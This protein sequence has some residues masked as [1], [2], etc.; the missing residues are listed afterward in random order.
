MDEKRRE[1]LQY[2]F[3]PRSIGILGASS[4][5][6][7]VSGR[8]LAY[9]LR[10]GY[11]GKIYPIN[12]KYGE[13][14][15]VKCYPTLKEVPGEIDTLIV[16]IPAREI[17][18]NLESGLER[19]VKAAVIISGGFAEIGE[20]GRKLQERLTSFA[21]ETGMLIYGPNTTGFLSLVNRTVATF[22]QGLEVI[23]EMVPGRA[24]LITQSGAFGAAIFVRAMRVGLG[25]SH[26][27]ATGNEADLEFCDFLEYMVDDPHT[28]VIVGFLAGVED[29]QNLIKGLDMAAKK[30]KP[31]VLLKVGG[32]QAGKRAAYSHTGAIVGSSRAYDA[33]FRQKGVIVARDIGELIDYSMAL[34]TTSPPRGRRVGIMTE[35]GG[36]GVL[37]TERCSELGLEVSEI[38]GATRERLKKVVP[39]V[40]SVKNPVDLTGQSLSIPSLVKGAIEV[41]LESED[42]D[43]VLPLLMMSEAT[44]KERAEDLVNLLKQHQGGKTVIVCWP[45]GPR[46]WIQYLM[47]KGIHV[48]ETP[49]RCAQTL[50]ALVQYA[51]FRQQYDGRGSLDTDVITDLPWDRKERALEVIREAKQRGE[52]RLSEYEG[53]RLLQ[54]Y[55]IPTAEEALA[56]SV[57][58]A[59]EIARRIGYPVVAKLISPDIPHKTEAGVVALNIESKAGLRKAY[60]EIIERGRAYRPDARVEGVLIQEMVSARGV[61]TIVGVSHEDPFGPMILFGLGGIFVETMQDVAIRILPVT[62]RDV[63]EMIRQIRGYPILQ[64][65]RGRSPADIEAL[66]MVLLKTA[67]L[68][69]EFKGVIAE[70]DINPLIVSEEGKGAKAVDALVLLHNSSQSTSS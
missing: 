30:G 33:V 2:L 54:A 27:A 59:I 31:V 60:Q 20:E 70:I 34:G 18:P 43:I 22:S 26:W 55:G 35:S 21:R 29:G 40:G 61:E 1:N 9:M 52:G 53:K 49:S 68:A 24:G 39:S 7:K 45:E 13:I 42:F 32:T 62:E 14:S 25:L 3:N 47:D 57:E 48:S 65:T 15:G 19:G 10:F 37:L 46:K 66:S 8:P 36:G 17:L 50:N 67:C 11:P 16:I 51:D 56:R 4:D 38:F 69:R 63:E 28:H 41:M 44:A 6:N 23:K 64:G 12:P 58:E 5:P